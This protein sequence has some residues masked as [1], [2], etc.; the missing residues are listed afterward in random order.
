MGHL[1]APWLNIDV[2]ELADEPEELFVLT[3]WREHR[4]RRPRG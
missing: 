3:P 4:V 1:G 2:G